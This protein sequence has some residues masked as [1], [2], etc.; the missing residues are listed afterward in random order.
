M[1]ALSGLDAERAQLFGDLLVIERFTDEDDAVRRSNAT[2]Y[3]LAASVW[4]S[5][6]LKAKRMASRLKFG[7]VWRNAHNRLFA[8]AETGGY[9]DS[10][11]GSAR[12]RYRCLPH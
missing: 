1:Q 3:S 4:T 8:E 9:G 11:Y 7:T 2:R 6:L 10:G 12:G 5:D